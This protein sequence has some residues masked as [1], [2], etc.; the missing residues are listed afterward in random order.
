MQAPTQIIPET[1][2]C[3][4]LG[5][6]EQARQERLSLMGLTEADI[7]ILQDIQQVAIQ[8]NLAQIM[9]DF[10]DFLFAFPAMRSFLGT[11]ENIQR[12]KLSQKEYLEN[13]G[14]RF[15]DISYFEYRLRIGIAHERI[16]LPLHLYLAAYREMQALIQKRLP[17][18]PHAQV[19]QYTQSVQSIQKIVTL[20]MS[21]AIDTYTRS[22][23][24]LMNASLQALANERDNLH[25]Q[26]MHDTLTGTLSR[27]FILEILNKQLAQL[28]RQPDRHLTVALLDLDHFKM[29]NDEFGHL[30]GDKVLYEFTRVASSRVRE[31]D[32]FGRFGGEEFLLILTEINTEEA[33][34]ALN[35]I[36]E[37]TQLQVFTHEGK[38][39]PLTVSIGFTAARPDE[40][41][42]DL[43]ERADTALYKA[44]QSGRNQLARG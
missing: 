30:V 12:L 25:N 33:S 5:F 34:V 35:R 17:S 10:Y 14:L 28:A 27:R 22:R 23:V 41:V 6:T 21:L 19:A 8:P 26:L 9:D 40:K 20:D 3:Q 11:A 36:R 42:D 37:A 13:F 24:E 7:P 2:L 31:Q 15:N 44:K 39:I 32:Y 38:H 18:T 29:V 43:I 4:Q 16:G 1:Y